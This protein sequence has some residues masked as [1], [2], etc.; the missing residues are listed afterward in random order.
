[1]ALAAGQKNRKLGIFHHRATF[2]DCAAVEGESPSL[3]TY[4]GEILEEEYR[5]ARRKAA[6][7]TGLP[8]STFPE[9]CP[10]TIEQVLDRDFLP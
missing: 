10:F 7:E 9:E 3:R 6:A 4:L 8:I 5:L 1:V 2:A